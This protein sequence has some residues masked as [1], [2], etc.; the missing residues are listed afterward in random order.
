[1][2]ADRTLASLIR[3]VQANIAAEF[4]SNDPGMTIQQLT[5]LRALVAH[6]PQSQS[7]LVQITDI[8]RSTLNAMLRSVSFAKLILPVRRGTDKMDGRTTLIA[9]AEDSL[10]LYR[11]AENAYTRAEKRVLRALS[12]FEREQLSR[13]LLAIAATP[14]S[15]DDVRS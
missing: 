5:V 11:R 8:D 2:S 12:K 13:M 10:P 14:R 6:G 4:C 9:M 3:R 7:A 15:L 1:M